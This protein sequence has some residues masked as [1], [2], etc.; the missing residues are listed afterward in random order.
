MLDQFFRQMT[1]DTAMDSAN[2]DQNID[3]T[4][5]AQAEDGEDA[6]AQISRV[7]PDIVIS[8]IRMPGMDGLTLAGE[9]YRRWPH[10]KTIILTGFPDFSYAQRAI[11]YQVVDFVL[12]PTSVEQLTA[13]IEKARVQ[14]QK[15]QTHQ[16]LRSELASRSEENLSLQQDMLLRDLIHRVRLST[17]YVY[18][19]M[20]QLR[21]DLR[22]YY[23]LSL[24]V[25]P[26]EGG[27][28]GQLSPIF[29]GRA[30]NPAGQYSGSQDMVYHRGGSGVLRGSPG[31]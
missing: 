30:G 31:A 26:L 25:E 8:D 19:C 11:A 20:A 27:G 5:V 1:P 23:V 24:M 6:L 18:S 14:I 4:V 2:G 9:L 7:L 21:M 22:N 28:G 3:T 10:I 13:A 16:K 12:K 29:A 15:E 17:L